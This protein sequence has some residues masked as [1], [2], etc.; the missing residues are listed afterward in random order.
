MKG[1]TAQFNFWPGYVAAIS[2][3]VLG[4]LL[5]ASIVAA[6]ISQLGL[7]GAKY[8]AALLAEML[9]R[10][11]VPAAQQPA[12]A[13]AAVQAPTVPAAVPV[14]PPPAA[15]VPQPPALPEPPNH[16]TLI[17]GEQLLDIPADRRDEIN[18]S[19]RG[20]TAS[21]DARWRIW[22]AAPE[23]DLT[24]RRNTFRLMVAVRTYLGSQGIAESRVELRLEDGAGTGGP[25]D[26][27][28]RFGPVQAA[29][30]A[31]AGAG[32]RP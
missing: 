19:L 18:R 8:S 21:A 29:P 27:V 23:N 20:L 4:L 3:L 2:C 28:V 9:R 22:A 11:E 10:V 16:V 5:V 30:A 14:P 6:L 13:R 24:T 7:I 32:A 15:A 25:G 1:P 17:F 31:A 12:P 26:I